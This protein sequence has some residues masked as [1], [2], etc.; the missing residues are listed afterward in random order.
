VR[1]I[2]SPHTV[3]PSAPRPPSG[4]GAGPERV[5]VLGTPGCPASRFTEDG[6]REVIDGDPRRD[7]PGHEELVTARAVLP[8]PSNRAGGE[9]KGPIELLLGAEERER[10]ASS[11]GSLLVLGR[12]ARGVDELNAGRPG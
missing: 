11:Q 1:A 2:P 3:H 12:E 10:L 7:L 5:D 8:G 4:R 6:H 9:I